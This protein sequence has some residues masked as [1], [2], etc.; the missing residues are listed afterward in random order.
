M[1]A[2]LLRLKKVIE[3]KD[4]KYAE[5]IQNIEKKVMQDKVEK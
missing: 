1:E 5:T 4:A 3:T 2:E